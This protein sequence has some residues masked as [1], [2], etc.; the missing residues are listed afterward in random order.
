MT[1]LK[2]GRKEMSKMIEDLER[3]LRVATQSKKFRKKK[4]KRKELRKILKACSRLAD[5]ICLYDAH[6]TGRAVGVG[7]FAPDAEID[8]SPSDSAANPGWPAYNYD[9]TNYEKLFK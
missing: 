3:E 6:L 4:L 1:T 8:V 7:I 2:E 9:L 5:N